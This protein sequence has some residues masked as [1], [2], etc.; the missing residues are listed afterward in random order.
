MIELVAAVHGA[1]AFDVNVNDTEPAAISADDGTYVA[2]NTF[3][4]GV[5]VPVP[6]VDHVPFDALPP[7]DPF[8]ATVF[9]A[10]T[11]V[12]DPALAV[13]GLTH[14]H[15]SSMLPSQLS[16]IPLPHTSV[17]PGLTFALLSLQSP[18]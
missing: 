16:S 6:L 8:K 3:A 13:G 5:N 4:D 14:P 10:H 7:I 9:P 18:D 12:F 2:F 11:F 15:P 1:T 17:A